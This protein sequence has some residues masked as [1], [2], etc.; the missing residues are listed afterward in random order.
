MQFCLISDADLDIRNSSCSTQPF[1]SEIFRYRLKRRQFLCPTTD[2][3][4][5]YLTTIYGKR[6]LGRQESGGD[7][8][9]QPEAE[10]IRRPNP[11]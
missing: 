2:Y 4:K 7:T 3:L 1:W 11:R 9:I 6:Y 8:S 5:D 10:Q